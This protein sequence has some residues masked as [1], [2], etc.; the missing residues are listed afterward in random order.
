M[1]GAWW[2]LTAMVVLAIAACACSGADGRALAAHRPDGAR[3]CELECLDAYV[4]LASSSILIDRQ[5]ALVVQYTIGNRCDHAVPLDLSR[6]RVV[7]DDDEER[8][9]LTPYDPRGE[10][11]LL[12]LAGRRIAREAIAYPVAAPDSLRVH[13]DLHGVADAAGGGDCAV[14]CFPAAQLSCE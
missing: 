14:A 8:R 9:E 2:R 3:R 5:P 13:I 10:I 4:G 11:R 7:V 12:P 6:V 1:R